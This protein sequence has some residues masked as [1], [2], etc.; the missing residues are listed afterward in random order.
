MADR[1]CAIEFLFTIKHDFDQNMPSIYA[2]TA[3]QTLTRSYLQSTL[4]L[5][6]IE[7]R[8][9]HRGV[10]EPMR[11]FLLQETWVPFFV[12][13]SDPFVGYDFDLHSQDEWCDTLADTRGQ[14]DFFA[15]YLVRLNSSF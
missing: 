14:V 12:S 2:I 8:I 1:L 9:H 3:L 5:L 15:T 4:F 6:L 10:G 11:L 13:C 7:D